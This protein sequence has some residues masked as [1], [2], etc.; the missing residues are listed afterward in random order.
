MQ[1][2][3]NKWYL[4]YTKSN[5]EKKLYEKII[6][7]GILAYL[8][9]RKIKKKWS[10]RIKMCEEPAFKSYVFAKLNSE[11]MRIVEQLSGFLFLVSYGGGK[12][13]TEQIKNKI[14]PVITDLTIEQISRTLAEYPKATLIDSS[15]IKGDKVEI[16]KGSL[17]HYQGNLTT[18]PEGT[19][20]AINLNG[21]KQSLI[22]TVPMELLKKIA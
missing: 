3:E 19:K 10:D 18:H 13:S 16:T 20:V 4:I 17:K 14:F 5:T 9:L 7:R 11:T 15:L 6:A 2:N 8:P 1:T 21:L 12:Q 22:I